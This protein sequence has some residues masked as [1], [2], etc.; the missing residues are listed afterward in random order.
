[1]IL[2]DTSIWVDHLRIGDDMLQD[3]LAKEQVLLHPFVFGELAL[4]GLRHRAGTLFQLRQLPTVNVA[5]HDEVMRLVEQEILYGLGL[6][7]I[8]AHVLAATRLTPGASLW[9]RDKSLSAAAEKLSVA[10]RV[11]H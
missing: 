9:S 4:G 10:A 3:L 2:V 1:V 11:T 5:H 8:D 6:S 7:Y